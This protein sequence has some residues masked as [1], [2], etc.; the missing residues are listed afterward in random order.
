MTLKTR[1]QADISSG[2]INTKQKLLE[3]AALLDLKVTGSEFV[4][5]SPTTRNLSVLNILLTRTLPP[6][7]AHSDTGFMR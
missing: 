6:A 3:R 2:E 4:S 7:S 5:A 1:L